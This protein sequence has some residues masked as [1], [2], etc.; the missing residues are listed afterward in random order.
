MCLDIL[1]IYDNFVSYSAAPD[2][3]ETAMINLIQLYNTLLK[4]SIFNSV[5]SGYGNDP[6]DGSTDAN[7]V[8]CTETN[9]GK[10]FKCKLQYRFAAMFNNYAGPGTLT[11]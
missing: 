3:D 10:S 8:T 5:K 4:Q 1:S 11:F 9:K 6:S 7:G 2:T